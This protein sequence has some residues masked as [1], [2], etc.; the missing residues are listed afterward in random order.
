M[1][2]LDDRLTVERLDPHGLLGRI[3]SLP[4]QCAEAWSRAREIGLPAAY[5]NARETVVVWP[6]PMSASPTYSRRATR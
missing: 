6:T 1:T 2:D 5:A 3:E 4:E